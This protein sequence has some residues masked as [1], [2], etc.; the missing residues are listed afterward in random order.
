VGTILVSNHLWL[1]YHR[2]I[3]RKDREGIVEVPFHT[4][5]KYLNYKSLIKISIEPGIGQSEILDELYGTI[6][7]PPSV[8]LV[9]RLTIMRTQY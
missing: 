9:N 3:K 6:L 8:E 4:N 5:I 2:R 1:Y 7:D